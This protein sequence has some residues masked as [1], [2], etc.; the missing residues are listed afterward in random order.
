MLRQSEEPE[1]EPVDRDE[2]LGEAIEAYLALVEAGS[3]ADPEEFASRY[4]DISEDLSAALEG[5]AMVQGL[6]GESSMGP[7]SRLEA[8]RRIAGYR[9]VRELGRGGM[10]VVYEA[11]HVDLDRPVALK[12]LGTHAAPDSSG[13]RRFLNE[14]KTAAGLHHTHIVPVFDVGQ[15]GGLCYYA[16]QR[17]EGSGLDRVVKSLRKGRSTAAGSSTGRP[18][19]DF[20]AAIDVSGSSIGDPTR[21]WYGNGGGAGRLG[22]PRDELDPPAFEPPR[23]SEYYRWVARVGEQAADA[24]AHAHRRGVVHRDVKPSNLLVDAR[25]TVWVADFGLARRLADPSQ[26]QVDSLLGTPRYMSPEQA[27]LGPIDGRTDVYSLGATLYELLTLRPPFEGRT[28][29]ELVGQIASNEPVSPRK[30]DPRLPRDLETI[31]LKAMGKRPGDRYAGATELAEDLGHFLAM[32]PVKARRIGPIGRTWRFVRRHPSLSIVSTAATAAILIVATVAHLS[33]VQGRDAALAAQAETQKALGDLRVEKRKTDV[34]RLEG[35]YREASVLRISSTPDR[36]KTGLARIKD[37]ARLG[38][39][40]GDTL[41]LRDEAVELLAIRDVEVRPGLNSGRTRSVA[42]VGDGNHLAAISLSDVDDSP[43]LYLWDVP[44][45]SHLD[46]QLV[47]APSWDGAGIVELGEFLATIRPGGDGLRLFGA[48]SG[49]FLTDLEMPERKVTA[50]YATRSGNRLIT[51]SRDPTADV[52]GRGPQRDGHRPRVELWNPSYIDRPLADLSEEKPASPA[53]SRGPFS[54][55]VLVAI[56]PDGKTIATVRGN[57]PKV[58]L[59]NAEDGQRRT[60]IDITANPTAIAVGPQGLLAVACGG[61]IQIWDVE[62]LR[63]LPGLNSRQQMI[64]FLRFSP[65]GLTLAVAGPG[66]VEVW[67]PASNTMV[68]TFSDADR[69]NDLAFS[70][71]GRTLATAGD[72][73]TRLWSIL[74]PIGRTRISGAEGQRPRSVAFGPDGLLAASFVKQAATG[75]AETV[76]RLWPSETCPT[77]ASTWADTKAFAVA[78]DARGRVALPSADAIRLYRYP[79]HAPEEA[80]PLP[81]VDSRGPRPP[82]AGPC[83]PSGPSSPRRDRPTAGRS[84]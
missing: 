51:V 80:V 69:I 62:K 1:A 31:V 45:R 43:G 59:W 12:V 73:G 81:K 79:E 77:K 8:G 61:A 25:G 48:S 46:W 2:R 11:V 41:K 71:D 32:E 53:E 3:P 9:I 60:A 47:D 15:V 84:S 75:D 50:L 82:G 52:P 29:A 18:L 17:I 33:V 56:G 22:G 10:G 39:D 19:G 67:A 63:P 23:G 36:R 27:K 83:S 40:A 21:S 66:G 16:M 78:F 38:P 58:S 26:T 20:A 76:L 74:E 7:G 30:I 34:A 35:L 49:V 5:L 13:R 54:D 68:A 55:R 14:A 28:A 44:R 37:A 24:L 6:V 42:F 64:R 65:D 4:P 57:T 70:A 72:G